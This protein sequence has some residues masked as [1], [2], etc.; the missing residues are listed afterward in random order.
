MRDLGPDLIEVFLGALNGRSWHG[1]AEYG[2]LSWLLDFSPILDDQGQVREVVC[3]GH[4]LERVRFDPVEGEPDP[5]VR[6]QIWEAA[7]DNA[8]HCIWSA[9]RFVDRADRDVIALWRLIPR[10]EFE[11]FRAEDPT[12]VHLLREFGPPAR[13]PLRLL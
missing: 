10:E 7:G 1:M 9:D 3:M 5:P 2:G 11:A 8:R 13:P 12:R 6:V 4:V